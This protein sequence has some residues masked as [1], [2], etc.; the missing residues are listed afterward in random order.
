M[1]LKSPDMES[2]NIKQRCL[3]GPNKGLAY[4]PADP[5]PAG[6]EFNA[7]ACDC[8]ATASTWG[9]CATYANSCTGELTC[10]CSVSEVGASGAPTQITDI[11]SGG[12]ETCATGG[13]AI[14][15]RADF[16][17]GS[18]V[19][20]PISS[21]VNSERQNLV[22]YEVVYDQPSGGYPCN[23]PDCTTSASATIKWKVSYATYS[24]GCSPT[25]TLCFEFGNAPY[26]RAVTDLVP[27]TQIEL[28]T[29]LT[30]DTGTCSGTENTMAV[31]TYL[32]CVGGSPAFRTIILGSPGCSVN[33]SAGAIATIYDEEIIY[34]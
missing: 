12:S 16:S 31:A 9:I 24:T 15:F 27:G 10:R 26:T 23:L 30:G 19:N 1:A 29:Q 6:T 34:N 5:C 13:W 28:G 4:D 17:D 21:G 20:V 11:S 22:S 3:T 2:C 33:T 25:T 18:S 7:T 8:S 14:A 32:A